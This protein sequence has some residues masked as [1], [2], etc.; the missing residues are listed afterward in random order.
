MYMRSH[1]YNLIFDEEYVVQCKHCGQHIIT[2]SGTLF[3]YMRSH[4]CN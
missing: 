1:E 3:V 2:C 4:E